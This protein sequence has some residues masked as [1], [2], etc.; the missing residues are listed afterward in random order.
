MARAYDLLQGW[1]PELGGKPM[2]KDLDMICH[3]F[4]TLYQKEVPSEEPLPV[5]V[6]L[7]SIEDTIPMQQPFS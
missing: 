2:D 5:H 3:D 7:A 6:Q 4:M 1:Y